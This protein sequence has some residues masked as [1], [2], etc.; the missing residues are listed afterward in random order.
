MVVT[1]SNSQVRLFISPPKARKNF[2]NHSVFECLQSMTSLPTAPFSTKDPEGW[3]RQL[4]AIFTISKI[5]DD[6]TKYVHLQARLDPVILQGVSEFFKDVPEDNKYTALKEKIIS[7]YAVPRDAQVLQLLEGLSL[8]DSRPSELLSQIQRLAATDI[9]ENVLRTMFLKKLPEL[10]AGTLAG[11]T[12]PLTN[13]GKMA[14]KI[15]AFL[16]SS[17]PAPQISVCSAGDPD[18]VQIK[19]MLNVM[20]E[21]QTKMLTRIVALESASNQTDRHSRRDRSPRSPDRRSRSGSRARNSMPPT[22]KVCYYHY[23]FWDKAKKCTDLPDGTPCKWKT[24]NS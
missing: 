5:E 21:S 7:K 17:T 16:P 13:L 1:R 11:S 9:S 14:D 2:T 3:F 12:E 24:L 4:E 15:Y 20:M 10:L 19:S 22:L 23:R 8:G 6:Q 18:I